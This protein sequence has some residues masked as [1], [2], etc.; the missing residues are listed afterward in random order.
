MIKKLI[1]LKDI[2]LNINTI[3]NEEQ[4][5]CEDNHNMNFYVKK[6]EILELP[7][8][9]SFNTNLSNFILLIKNKDFLNKI[10][11]NEINL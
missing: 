6:Y 8:I 4:W 9:L 7:F 3:Y 10:M 1:C 5:Y 2:Y 11:K